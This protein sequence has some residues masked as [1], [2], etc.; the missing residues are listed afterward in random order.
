MAIILPNGLTTQE[1][2]VLQEF[3]RLNGETLTLDQIK[4]IRHPGGAGGE[5][6]AASLTGK[7]YL[8]GSDGGFALT[9]QAKDFL[10]IDATPLV[11]GTSDAAA[12]AAE[13]PDADGV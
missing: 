7:G 1:I 6:P 13:N 5:A 3:R 8:T 11:G 10:S 2:R 12:S 9:Q 4:A